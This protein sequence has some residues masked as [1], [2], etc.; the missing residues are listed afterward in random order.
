MNG[1]ISGGNTTSV[2]DEERNVRVQKRN[3]SAKRVAVEMA[4]AQYIV[5]QI[6]RSTYE[7]LGEVLI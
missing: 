7:Q 4:F 3:E 2:A 6:E 1:I 5:K